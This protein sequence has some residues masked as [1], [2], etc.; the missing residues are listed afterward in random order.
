LFL[1]WKQDWRQQ[2]LLLAKFLNKT[3]EAAKW[4]A[5]Y[6]RMTATV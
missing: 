1:S 5:R 3:D 6:E 2:L 4:L